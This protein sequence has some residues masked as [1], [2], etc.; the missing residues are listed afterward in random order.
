M[1]LKKPFEVTV[2]IQNSEGDDLDQLCIEDGGLKQAMIKLTNLLQVRVENLGNIS[3]KANSKVRSYEIARSE[4]FRCEFERLLN[5]LRKELI[6]AHAAFDQYSYGK[7]GSAGG[8][9]LCLSMRTT[10]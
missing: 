6:V 9:F 8:F 5:A 3:N 10:F 7:Y 4:V 1:S 2:E